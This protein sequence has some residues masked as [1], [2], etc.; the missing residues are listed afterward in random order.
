MSAA[1]V[2]IVVLGAVLSHLFLQTLITWQSRGRA[3]KAAEALLTPLGILLSLVPGANLLVF[4][5][6]LLA[7]LAFLREKRIKQERVL[8]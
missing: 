3:R 7:L 1:V 2:V 8:Q 5:F 4:A 6:G